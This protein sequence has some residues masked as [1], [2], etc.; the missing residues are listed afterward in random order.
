MRPLIIFATALG[1]YAVFT[2]P[3]FI[4]PVMY[5]VSMCYALVYGWI[6]LIVFAAGFYIIVKKVTRPAT[7]MVLLSLLV[8]VSV[9]IAFH[10]LGE[11]NKELD[12]WHSGGFLIFPLTAVI[13]G[14]TS[15]FIAKK[16]ILSINIKGSSKN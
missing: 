6:A 12:A 13:A 2:L 7:I 5:L 3:A 14:I 15:V 11:Y 16:E 9:A 8:V 1:L 10:V 4:F